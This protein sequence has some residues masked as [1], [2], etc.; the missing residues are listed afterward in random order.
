MRNPVKN[1]KIIVNG[2]TV[3]YNDEGPLNA[4]TIIFIHGF[5]LNK[6]M[7]GAQIDALKEDYRVVAYDIRGHG[8]SD[9][10]DENFSMDIFAN[11]LL[12]FMDALNIDKPVLCGLSMGGYI[13]LNAIGKFPQH[14]AALVL[15]DTQCLADSPDM[16]EKRMKAIESINKSGVE[17]YAEESI[18]NL[19][20]PAS[21]TTKKE[22][23]SAVR[24]MIVQTSKQSLSYTLFALSERKGTCSK[25]QDIEVPVLI[26]VGK[27]DKI[28]PPAAA[29]LMHEK[30]QGSLI[31]ILPHAGHLANMENA[32]TF[33]YQL[34]SFISLVDK[35]PTPL[36][37]ARNLVFSGL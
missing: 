23:I 34:R 35:E 27:E 13:A 12:F 1:L 30:I 8:D 26:M 5:P 36:A 3:S 14:F 2:L 16:R 11:D 18:K 19:F 9:A 21:F 32:S 24:K 15:S 28:T 6:S 17:K 25:L 22:E 29:Q 7:W 31:K 10:G 33:N 20:A 37:L 4:P